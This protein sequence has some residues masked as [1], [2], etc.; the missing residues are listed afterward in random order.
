MLLNVYQGI[1]YLIL[2][3]K[4]STLYQLPNYF[5]ESG[6]SCVKRC[7]NIDILMGV[8]HTQL[9]HLSAYADYSETGKQVVQR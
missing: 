6:N 4:T 2:N 7:Q 3:V 9:P 8:F 1:F 5:D